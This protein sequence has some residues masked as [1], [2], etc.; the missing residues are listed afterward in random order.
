MTDLLRGRTVLVT[1]STDGVGKAIARSLAT[2]GAHV[3]VSGPSTIA[4]LQVVVGI[5]QTGGDA[6]YLLAAPGSTGASL[7]ALA[8]GDVL[9]THDVDLVVAT[10]PGRCA[11]GRAGPSGLQVVPQVVR[12][13]TVID[14]GPGTSPADPTVT[15]WV[16]AEVVRLAVDAC[17]PWS[18]SH[19]DEEQDAQE[20]LEFDLS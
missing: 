13:G 5:H 18:V 8:D 20:E 1:A 2:A 9:R 7:R 3:I 12:T 17:A 4:G 10:A 11:T 14:V 16:A 15:R 6:G 19:L